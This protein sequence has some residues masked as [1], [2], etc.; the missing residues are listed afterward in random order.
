L[1]LLFV[2]LSPRMF[3]H[4]MNNPKD[5]PFAAAYIF[6]VYHSIRFTQ[7]LPK[8]TLRTSLAVIIGIAAAI[9]IRIGGLLL[10]AYLAA[11]SGIT[12]LWKNELRKELINIPLMAKMLLIGVVIAVA[13]LFCGTLYWP[14]GALDWTA[15]PFEVLEKMSH[16]YVGIRVLCSLELYSELDGL[17]NTFICP[18]WIFYGSFCGVFT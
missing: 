6:T 4:S 10:I 2:V 5:I 18:D 12:F 1:A 8:P 13:G 17:Y 7:Q 9:N 3:G 15:K 14:Y 11:F 16:Y